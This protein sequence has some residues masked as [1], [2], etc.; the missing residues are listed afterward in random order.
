MNLVVNQTRMAKETI[1]PRKVRLIFMSFPNTPERVEAD[2]KP[3][4]LF[5]AAPH[6]PLRSA[7]RPSECLVRQDADQRVREG[8]QQRHGQANDERSVDQ[9]GE[10]EHAA[11]QQR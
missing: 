7:L 1:W 5:A 2:V 4:L 3:R 10:Q 9:A 8:E 6:N 11:L